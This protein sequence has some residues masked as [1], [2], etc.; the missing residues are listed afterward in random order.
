M[1]LFNLF[2]SQSEE[3]DI[4]RVFSKNDLPTGPGVGIS[5]SVE[6]L[7]DVNDIMKIYKHLVTSSEITFFVHGY[8]I[9]YTANTKKFGLVQGMFDRFLHDFTFEILAGGV[10]Y[11]VSY[12]L[13]KTNTSY[14]KELAE[15]NEWLTDKFF[16][17]FE[18][19][20]N[21]IQL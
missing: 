10:I 9:Y 6:G 21:E 20:F 2:N 17:Y 4:R 8:Y 1:G 19:Y 15:F 5:P 16:D 18:E 3:P 13:G 14:K 12:V 7:D 11:K